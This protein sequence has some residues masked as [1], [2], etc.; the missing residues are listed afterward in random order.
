MTYKIEKGVPIPPKRNTG[1]YAYKDVPFDEMEVN[2][3]VTIP[4]SKLIP[5]NPHPDT[6]ER[7]LALSCMSTYLGTK[8]PDKKFTYRTDKPSVRSYR[9]KNP[10]DKEAVKEANLNRVVRVW[11]IK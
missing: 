6:R 7:T 2:D 4:I 3:C 1:L 11:R 9:F 10:K 8:Y 5:D